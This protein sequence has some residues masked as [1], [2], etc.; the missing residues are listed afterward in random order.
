M[1]FPK[2]IDVLVSLFGW[3]GA[4]LALAELVALPFCQLPPRGFRDRAEKFSLKTD[5]GLLL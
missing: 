3:R 2:L 1:T 4:L 5:A